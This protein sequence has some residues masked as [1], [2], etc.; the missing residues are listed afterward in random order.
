MITH[1]ICKCTCVNISTVTVHV[2]VRNI[3][4]YIYCVYNVS[5]AQCEYAIRTCSAYGL[6]VLHWEP[7]IC[8]YVACVCHYFSMCSDH[9]FKNVHTRSTG[10]DIDEAVRTMALLRQRIAQGAAEMLTSVSTCTC[11]KFMY[12]CMYV[13]TY[14]S[15]KNICTT[16]NVRY[17]TSCN[18][19]WGWTYTNYN[20]RVYIYIYIYIYIYTGISAYIYVCI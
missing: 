10:V 18:Y 6:G 14:M 20:G 3:H 17:F 2:C 11:M 7:S 19:I 1:I 5:Q 8:I 13:C 12:V 15:L 4:V 9:H 16:L